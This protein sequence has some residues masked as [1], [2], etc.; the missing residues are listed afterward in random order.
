MAKKKKI[1]RPEDCVRHTDIDFM[2]L[3]YCMEGY[4]IR[5][6]CYCANKKAKRGS[7]Q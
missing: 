3:S 5:V 2:R 6:L 7:K 1:K 4:R